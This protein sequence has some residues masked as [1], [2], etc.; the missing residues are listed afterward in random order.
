MELITRTEDLAAACAKLATAPFI[1][2]DTEFMREQTFWPRLCLVQIAGGETEVL[3]DSM[4]PDIDLKPLF[5]LMVDETVLKV[6]HSARQDVEI[7]HHLAGVIPHPIFDTQ[8]AA[9]VCGFG[10]AVS[11]SMLVK[12]LL[13][14][15]LDK[16]S[17]FTDWSRRP[18]SERQLTYALGDVTYL[19]DLY[20]K[21]RAQLDQSE[22]ASWLNEEMAVLTDPATYELHPE[23]A[24]RRLKMRIKTP[25]ALAILMELA[26]WREREAQ[27]QDIPR[28]RVLKDE[29]LYD[30]AGQAPRSVE[31][32]GSLRSLHNGFARSQRGRAV[33]EAVQRGRERDPAT[34]PPLQR[35]E[36]MP[37]EAQ[38]V[39]DL[40]RVLLKAT[41]G[42]HGVAP[43][44]I[45]TSDDLEEIARSDDADAAALRGWRRKLF[46]EDALALKRGELALAVKEGAVTVLAPEGSA[47]EEPED[48]A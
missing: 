6:F 11:Y 10:E 25:K 8:V 20:P 32:L 39:V 41:A 35:G 5:D 13:G 2:V 19:R 22:R 7:V 24:W 21:L 47:A 12:R 23:H 17:R 26:A 1:A 48:N 46:G 16:S 29:A 18:L 36:P 44:L 43:K 3:I 31:D 40:L 42:R 9:M 30:I 4:A 28:S 33:L 14:R 15:N 38:A 37:P 45:A 34:V 27:T